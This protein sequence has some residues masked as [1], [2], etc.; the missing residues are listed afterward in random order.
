MGTRLRSA[1][2]GT[3]KGLITIGG[4]TLV[5]RSVRL[6][7]EAGIESMTIVAGYAEEHYRQ[8]ARGARDVRIVVNHDYATTGSMASLAIALE[9][10][11]EDVLV[12]ESDI[13]YEPRALTTLLQGTVP[14]V[15]LISGPT[16]AGDEVWVY[17]PDGVLQAMSKDARQLPERHGEFVGITRLSASATALMRTAYTAFVAAHG[18][19]RM[20]YESDALV[21]V[22]R[23]RPVHAAL[24]ADL[25]WGEIDDERHLARVTHDV[26]P[27]LVGSA[28]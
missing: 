2:Q 12:L 15:T 17:A 25:W 19:G 3:P 24:L 22:A 20:D 26:W 11:H 1:V 5:G 10:V 6:L 27:H 13:V 21:T 8:F 16:A 28:R 23:D 18:H 7:R 9:T 14:D 4:E